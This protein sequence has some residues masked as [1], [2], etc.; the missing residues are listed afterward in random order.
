MIMQEDIV[1]GLE[2]HVQLLTKTKIFCHCS[3]DYIDKEPNT[4]TCPVCLGLPGCLPVLNRKAVELAIRTAIALHCRINHT[5]IFH[6]KN[7][8]Y[9]DLPK[10]YQISQYDFPLAEE[11]FL[12][13]KSNK[14]GQKRKISIAR[15]HME[16][17]AGKLV[18]LEENGLITDSLVDFNRC[19][20][21]LLEI[22][23][24]PEIKSAKEAI[25]FL[26]TLRSMVQYL[27]VCDGNLERGSMRCDAN[28]SIRD[29]GSHQLGTKTEV[30]NMNSFRAIRRA[31]DYE[32]TR[33]RKLIQ[34]GEK[35][36]QETRRWDE[37]NNQTISM[38]SKEEAHDYRYFPEPDLLPLKI[39]QSWIDEI[40]NNLPELPEDR[41]ARFIREFGLSDYDA[42]R[43]VEI[44]SL[45][46]Y[47]EASAENYRDYKKLTNWILS[48]L[49][50]YLGEGNID[51]SLSPISAK[52]LAELL[53]LID[54]KIISG[55]IAKTIFEKMFKTGQSASDLV[56]K[57]GLTQI[58]DKDAI[59]VIIEKV[60]KENIQ[61]VKDYHSG[62]EKAL[63]FMVG[64][65][66]RYTKGRAQPDLVLDL[67]KEKMDKWKN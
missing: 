41:K 6:R 33:Q 7:Y 17:D 24:K 61:S 36:A 37:T 60:I 19:G 56:Q 1:I 5:N 39:K 32:I 12:E 2:I 53:N 43:L 57:S 45:G 23:T 49:L 28:I 62:K 64:Q 51:I 38:R 10:A 9:P 66:M 25:V 54:G 35:V 52:R 55:K 20:I 4:N 15:A 27:G 11:G 50:R 22:V 46:D 59:D 29:L 42:S 40:K 48:E 47:F 58:S 21:P 14:S 30:K 34:N 16:E 31:L 63:N 44:K 18:H 13:I 8:F 65:V 26:Q 67:L 3:T